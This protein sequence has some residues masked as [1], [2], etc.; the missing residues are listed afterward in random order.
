MRKQYGRI[1][2]KAP[3]KRGDSF[4]GP[5]NLRDRICRIDVSYAHNIENGQ[6]QFYFDKSGAATATE[7]TLNAIYVSFIG[8]DGNKHIGKFNC[9]V[10][11]PTGESN[12]VFYAPKFA[13]KNDIDGSFEIQSGTGFETSFSDNIVVIGADFDFDILKETTKITF[14]D[15]A[16]KAN[17]KGYS[18]WKI[19]NRLEWVKNGQK[20]H[21]I[22]YGF[23]KNKFNT[24]RYIQKFKG[25][26]SEFP[27]IFYTR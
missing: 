9:S 13:I 21:R 7:I 5:G 25:V 14:G 19:A 15:G 24:C 23:N 4:H 27:E 26:E 8:E 2:Y 16:T 17:R 3:T 6:Y 22:P 11:L 1:E 20:C 10:V 12:G 18:R